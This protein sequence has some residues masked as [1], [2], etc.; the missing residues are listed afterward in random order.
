[1]EEKMYDFAVGENVYWQDV[2]I[3]EY[4]KEE[5]E[6]QANTLWTIEEINTEDGIIDEDTIILIKSEYGSQAEVTA[7][8]LRRAYFAPTEKQ[9]ILIENAKKALNECMANGISFYIDEFSGM[10]TA[11][12]TENRNVSGLY[13]DQIGFDEGKFDYVTIEDANGIDI[14]I[15]ARVYD[16]SDEEYFFLQY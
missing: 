14:D 7:N 9:R 13:A 16:S 4:P 15:A 12:N 8:E 3:H 11:L 2:A 10:I 6:K 5:Q 1:M